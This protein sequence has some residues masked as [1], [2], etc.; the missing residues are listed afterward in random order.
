MKKMKMLIESTGSKSLFVVFISLLLFATILS[1]AARSGANEAEK[2]KIVRQVAQKWIQVGTEQYQ[3][4]FYKKAEQSFLRAQDYEE[5]L[6]AAD[7]KTLSELIEMTHKAAFERGRALEY[8]TI[9]DDLIRQGKRKEAVDYLVSAK[10]SEFFSD[11][12]RKEIAER[13]VELE[14][15]VNAQAVKVAELYNRSVELY[16]QGRLGEA[17]DGFAELAKNELSDMPAGMTPKD[18]L[19]K[20]DNILAEKVKAEVTDI[21]ELKVASFAEDKL[22]EV[23]ANDIEEAAVPHEGIYIEAVNRKMSIVRGHTE[24]VVNDTV[25]KAQAYLNQGQFSAASE[26]VRS[27]EQVVNNN[28]LHL[29]KDIYQNYTKELSQLS[30]E[31]SAKQK[32]SEQQLTT[33]KQLAAIEAQ[34]PAVCGR[35]SYLPTHPSG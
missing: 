15:Q 6:T 10:D 26:A 16:Q 32:E 7:R 9:V 1:G 14:G 23:K 28:Q 4:G 19:L 20:I 17:R 29:G 3:R 11:T 27:A 35:Q 2:Q 8:K 30:T 12:E 31:I 18:Y 13:L 33:Q 24:A 5:Y 22:V 25:A 21:E 34:L